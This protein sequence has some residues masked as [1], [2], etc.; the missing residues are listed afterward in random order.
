M[1][2]RH[3]SLWSDLERTLGPCVGLG[4]ERWRAVAHL[5]PAEQ[6]ERLGL[7]EVV[8]A[9]RRRDGALLGVGPLWA[10]L[11]VLGW[12]EAHECSFEPYNGAG[13]PPGAPPVAPVPA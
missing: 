2:R 10:C 13:L 5:P 4:P 7:A 6:L 9:V 3:G 12:A 1:K 11:A 8:V